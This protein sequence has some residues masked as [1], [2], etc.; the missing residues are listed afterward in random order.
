MRQE[1]QDPPEWEFTRCLG[2]TDSCVDS[3]NIV[4]SGLGLM[5]SSPASLTPLS[6]RYREGTAMSAAT[7][8]DTHHGQGKVCGN[9]KGRGNQ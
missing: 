1:R 4:C 5:V 8:A 9:G 7:T 6:I 2:V 3:P